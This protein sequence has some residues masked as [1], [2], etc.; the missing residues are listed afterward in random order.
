MSRRNFAVSFLCAILGLPACYAPKYVVPVDGPLTTVHFVRPIP[1]SQV[2]VGF[3]EEGLSC[4]GLYSHGQYGTYQ[5]IPPLM[6]RA[7]KPLTFKL[8]QSD[9]LRRCQF[10]YMFTPLEGEYRVLIAPIASLEYCALRVD[11]KGQVLGESVWMPAEGV[12]KRLPAQPVSSKD[13]W[14]LP[15]QGE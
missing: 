6:A 15:L 12:V 7:G 8:Q 11:I 14:C 13:P 1:D 4:K 10:L 2:W 5:E 3:F 9:P